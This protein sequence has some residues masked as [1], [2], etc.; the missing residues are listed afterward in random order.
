M[1]TNNHGGRGTDGEE[2]QIHFRQLLC[3]W[4]EPTATWEHGQV[5]RGTARPPP[6]GSSHN[7]MLPSSKDSGW[8]GARST[9]LL[10]H[11]PTQGGG[12]GGMPPREK[13][14]RRSS[15]MAGPFRQRLLTG[16][17]HLLCPHYDSFFL[18]ANP[19]QRRSFIS[20]AIVRTLIVQNKHTSGDSAASA[21]LYLLQ[22]GFLKHTESLR[23]AAHGA[24]SEPTFPV[25]GNNYAKECTKG[26]ISPKLDLIS[27]KSPGQLSA[28]RSLARALC[29]TGIYKQDAA[30]ELGH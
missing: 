2:G 1:Y 29:C 20:A 30:H 14:S 13:P 15:G 10:L 11:T 9:T 22:F 17:W 28:W 18:R 8:A 25:P 23:C 19:R 3:S 16:E 7:Q 26:Q 12:S 24:L 21:R 27:C 4:K 6:P 5:G